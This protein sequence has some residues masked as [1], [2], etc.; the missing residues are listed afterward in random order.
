V[1]ENINSLKAN[2]GNC[3]H[4]GLKDDPRTILSY[5]TVWNYCQH[6]KPIS[7]PKF[8]HQ[9][10]FCLT[11]DFTLCP[12]YKEN[13]G[14]SLPRELRHLYHGDASSKKFLRKYLIGALIVLLFVIAL[15][16][17]ILR[18]IP[19]M[20]APTNKLNP[21][22]TAVGI[23]SPTETI[24]PTPDLDLTR[25]AE[26]LS[27]PTSTPTL[28]PTSTVPINP[29][30]LDSP[31]GTNPRFI[32]HRV[33][34]GENLDLYAQDYHTTIEAIRAVNYYLPTPLWEDWLIVI[35]LDTTDTT[36]LPAFEAY[37]V[38]EKNITIEKLAQ[39]NLVD[40]VLLK[41]YNG[42]PDNYQLT[43]G[44]WILIPRAVL[45]SIATP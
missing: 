21:T 44:E 37:M 33:K 20:Q 28:K 41:K 14:S 29:H 35:P 43:A 32:I 13:A 22:L 3:P 24:P 45:I 17:I 12:V 30:T 42:Y 2:G 8:E 4:L 6:C 16:F 40:P 23:T 31:I 38:T 11:S 19:G 10:A 1:A 18:L 9:R 25:T 36:N 7:V 5:P 27:Q 39:S 34:S 15:I 26:S